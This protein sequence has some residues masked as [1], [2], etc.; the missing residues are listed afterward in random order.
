MKKKLVVLMIVLFSTNF[1][2]TQCNNFPYFIN[3]VINPAN[4]AYYNLIEFERLCLILPDSAD[5]LEFQAEIKKAN[6]L[7]S[8]INDNLDFVEVA[9][10]NARTNAENCYCINGQKAVYRLEEQ[11]EKSTFYLD[12]ALKFM[13]SAL[14][15]KDFKL[16][17]QYINTALSYSLETKKAVDEIVNLASDEMDSCN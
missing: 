11:Y 6:K 10:Q 3:E 1:A 17:K 9:I 16:A 8:T 13:K 4:E 5:I 7:L 2:F 15:T 14:K 12:K